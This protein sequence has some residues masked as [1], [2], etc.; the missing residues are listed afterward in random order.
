[1]QLAKEG[2]AYVFDGYTRGASVE[3]RLIA[4]V[5]IADTSAIRGVTATLA[6]RDSTDTPPTG[7][8][9]L[10]DSAHSAVIHPAV[11]NDVDS[12]PRS[13]DVASWTE[14]M[15][16][17]HVSDVA[18]PQT[19]P[20]TDAAPKALAILEPTDGFVSP[21]RDQVRVRAKHPL[22]VKAV[23]TVNGETIDDQ[24]IGQRTIDVAKHEETTT[25][26]GVHLREGWNSVIVRT[27]T[28][29]LVDSVR[30]ALS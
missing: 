9:N 17:P 1:R 23:L 26:Y 5:A 24:L 7:G 11:P 18:T 22:G 6:L 4:T 10:V 19:A 29:E 20:A 25:W 15:P 28:P 14:R 2:G 16:A 8:A 30:V 21:D 27:G 12:D 3:C 13:Y